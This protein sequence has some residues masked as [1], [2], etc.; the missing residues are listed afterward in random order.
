MLHLDA[1]RIELISNTCKVLILPL[2]YAK[3]KLGKVGLIGIEPITFRYE[4]NILPLNYRM[5]YETL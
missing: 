4:R 5:K 1:I 2:N 3:R